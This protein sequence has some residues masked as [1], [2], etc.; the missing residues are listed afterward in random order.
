MSE[1]DESDTIRKEYLFHYPDRGAPKGAA[2]GPDNNHA[3]TT[4]SF[5]QF[6]LEKE[7]PKVESK[8]DTR[9]ILVLVTNVHLTTD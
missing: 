7:E 4:D 5:E 2:S 8:L 6:V 9:M 3:N 1:S